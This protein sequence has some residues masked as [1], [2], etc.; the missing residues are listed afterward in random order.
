MRTRG[1]TLTEL[2]IG[3]ALFT[4]V[5]LAALALMTQASVQFNLTSTE[6][7]LNSENAQGLRNVQKALR[8]AMS[9]T[10]NSAGTRIDYTMPKLS[11]TKDATTGEFEYVDPL[12]S[13]GAAHYFIVN[14]VNGNLVDNNNHVICRNIIKTDPDP[15]STQ[16]GKAYLPFQAS[17]VGSVKALTITL[18]TQDQVGTRTR[19]VRYKTSVQL[20][21]VQ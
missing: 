15:S 6:T 9:A 2:V 21:N 20:R 8:G 3:L 4:I 1:F 19:Y 10:I 16:F 5:S 11:T 7:N 18:I 17:N 13:D 14:M 12:V